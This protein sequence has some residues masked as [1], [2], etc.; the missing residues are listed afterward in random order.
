MTN[1]STL[2]SRLSEALSDLCSRYVDAQEPYC[3]D[4]EAWLSLSD[5]TGARFVSAQ[6]ELDSVR[7]SCRLLSLYN[8]FAVNAHENRINFLVGSG[9]Q[10][11]AVPRKGRRPDQ[12]LLD[13]ADEFL[14]D[15]IEANHWHK[16]QQ[17]IVHRLDRD[18]EVF[19]RLFPDSD[20][21]T[22][23]RFIDPEQV[24]SSES[25]PK[26]PGERFGIVFDPNDAETINGFIVDKNFVDSM[27]IQHRKANVDANVP[28]GL[29]LFFPVRKNLR[30]AEKLLRNMSVVA[31]IQSAIAIIRR[32]QTNNVSAVERF[33]NGQN[34]SGANVSNGLSGASG[35]YLPGFSQY[36]PGTILDTSSSIDYQFPVAAIDASRY[37]T[38]LQAELRAIAARLVM[39]EF[40][41]TSDASNANYSSTMVA[42]GPAVRMFDRLQHELVCEDVELIKIAIRHAASAGRLPKEVLTDVD[43]RAVVP[44]LAVRNRLEETQADKILLD[45]GVMSKRTLALRNNLDPSEVAE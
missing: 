20:G 22:R 41:L 13:H 36:G 15:F 28:R 31:E 12:T 7:R 23:L 3:D 16:R 44:N 32:H 34:S 17:E 35:A 11:T 38:V 21:M 45:A 1:L 25:R 39:P 27:Y 29:P 4:D 14:Y 19:I 8:E 40:M 5:E 6:E 9:H 42:E 37:V 30:R 33:L 43:I 10:Y 2:E 18:G 26:R 24:Y